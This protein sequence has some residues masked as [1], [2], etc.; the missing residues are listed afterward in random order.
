[1]SDDQEDARPESRARTRG[2]STAG[3][4]R[5]EALIK[6][7]KYTAYATPLVIASV[8]AASGEPPISGAPTPPASPPSLPPLLVPP[9]PPITPG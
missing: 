1:M 5:R 9:T 3:S 4:E 8:S 2:I 7:G 6:L